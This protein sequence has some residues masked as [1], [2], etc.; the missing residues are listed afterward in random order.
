MFKTFALTAVFCLLGISGILDT[1][2]FVNV[3]AVPIPAIDIAVT[4]TD[5][6]ETL[7][8]TLQLFLLISLLTLA[9]TLILMF[10]SFTRLIVVLHFLRS[11][12]GTQQMPPNQILV[13]LAL[14]L[15]LF[16]MGDIFTEINTYALQPYT[17]GEIS[18]AEAL[19]RGWRPLHDFMVDQVQNEDMALFA[20]LANMT[21]P[22]YDVPL[23]ILVPAFIISELT[24]GFIIGFI[25]YLPFIV[26]DMIVAS[27]LMAMGMMMLPPAMISLPFKI[28]LFILGGGWSFV[29]EHVLATFRVTGVG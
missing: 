19:E 29:I 16:L 4:G 14:F 12:M 5:D 28:L 7:V 1:G 18:Q 23:R 17:M 20:G 10:T 25:L 15:T 8:P 27:I 24:R 9:P 6:P 26:I 13:G 11:A 2:I 21:I 3:N 22:Q